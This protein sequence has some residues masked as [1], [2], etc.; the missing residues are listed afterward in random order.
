VAEHRDEFRDT[1]ITALLERVAAAGEAAARP[2]PPARVRALAGHR[3]QQRRIA[4]VA[5][6]AAVA[7][8]VGVAGLVVEGSDQSV[9]SDP[10]DGQ[11]AKDTVSADML[12]DPS[13]AELLKGSWTPSATGDL[14]T[15]LTPCQL[16]AGAVDGAQVTRYATLTGGQ[17]GQES[18]A[19]MIQQA[20]HI[21]SARAG[22]Q[23]AV[24][25][26]TDC[27]RGPGATDQSQA[28]DSLA[29]RVAAA[30]PVPGIDDLRV[31]VVRRTGVS[32]GP[33]ADTVAAVV[34][35]GR[36]VSV[37]TWDLSIDDDPPALDDGFVDLERTLAA[38]LVRTAVERIPD[39]ALLTHSVPEVQSVLNSTVTTYMDM[40]KVFSLDGLC[41]SWFEPPTPGT[42]ATSRT[43][44]VVRPSDDG[45]ILQEV[46]AL[47]NSIP[48]A[49][50]ALASAASA[51]HGCAGDRLEGNRHRVA[52][53]VPGMEVLAWSATS[54]T[55]AG[56]TERRR[57]T[58]VF[59]HVRVVG[60]LVID[61]QSPLS[62]KDAAQ[63]VQAAAARLQTVG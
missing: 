53:S 60:Y 40:Q 31:F 34:R 16:D 27:A 55:A 45:S 1:G 2:A 14:A 20:P 50:S 30:A 17:S 19:Q 15:R 41:R 61:T 13:T 3:T 59:R 29:R 22:Y 54:S 52:V 58:A 57:L 5:A 7:L 42:V 56:T 9:R 63:I 47:H 21:Q 10:A 44:S 24:G 11:T 26:F 12:I 51:E 49:I 37:L 36:L 4:L 48:S 35:S 18:V 23:R 32:P 62:D 46:A 43:V 8:L 39:S 28:P 25:W 6:A 33:W 38:H